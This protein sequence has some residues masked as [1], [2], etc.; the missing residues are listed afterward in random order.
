LES[1]QAVKGRSQWKALLRHGQAVSLIDDSYN[2]N[3]DSV[4][5]A[6]DVL[7]ALPAPR[8]LVLGDMGEVGD[9]GPAFHAEIG[10]YAKAHGI[11]DFWCVGD[12]CAHAANAFAGARYFTA[13][14]DMLAAPEP[15]FNAVLIK[16]SRF[17]KMERMVSK[18]MQAEAAHAA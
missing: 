15:E 9:Q 11:D 5:A 13:V 4:R 17:M 16:G 8:W 1:F 12:L 6:I 10:A 3:P 14:D 2:A 18:L 7:A